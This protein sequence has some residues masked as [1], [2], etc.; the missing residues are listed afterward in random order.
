MKNNKKINYDTTGDTI[1]ESLEMK[2]SYFML[3]RIMK[4]IKIK[5]NYPLIKNKN[6][7]IIAVKE[8]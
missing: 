3:R 5:T 6:M 7:D 4:N 8:I 2:E 1:K